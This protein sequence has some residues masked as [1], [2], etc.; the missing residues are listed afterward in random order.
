M[1][2]CFPVHTWREGKKKFRPKWT[3]PELNTLYM[4][5]I[6]NGTLLVIYVTHLTML[7]FEST[8]VNSCGFLRRLLTRDWLERISIL[9]HFC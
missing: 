5:N 7:F 2:I 8:L 4:Y 1:T 9:M 3:D 6:N